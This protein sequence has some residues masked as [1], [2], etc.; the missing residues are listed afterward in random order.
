MI[1]RDSEGKIL[2]IKK[3]DVFQNDVLP[4]Y[5]KH[6]NIQ[7]FVRQLHIYDFHKASTANPNHIGYANVM[8]RKNRPEILSQ[9]LSPLAV[10]SAC[11]F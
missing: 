10:Y 1:C 11:C 6:S 5:F 7:S 4:R 3:V 9:V 2:L 8:F